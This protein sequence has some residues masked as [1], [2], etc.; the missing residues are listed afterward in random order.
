MKEIKQDWFNRPQ[1]VYET[2]D[3][4]FNPLRDEF[5]I[6]FDVCALPENAKCEKFFS[7]EDDGLSRKW[8]GVCW[9]N[10]PFGREMK[11]WVKKAFSDKHIGP[12]VKGAILEIAE[13]MS[14]PIPTTE[15]GF[16][17]L[18]KQVFVRRIPDYLKVNPM[19]LVIQPVWK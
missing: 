18:V 16:R 10:P 14:V 12:Y 11:K 5:G 7:P 2:P 3:V 19:L 9:M 6:D 15:S 8:S 1:T 13:L 4:I 17:E